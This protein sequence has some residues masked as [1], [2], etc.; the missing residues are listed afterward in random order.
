[1]RFTILLV[2]FAVDVLLSLM[3]LVSFPD[4]GRTLRPV[5]RA[6]LLVT[7]LVSW[8]GSLIFLL[9]S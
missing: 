6:I 8:A 3:L 5:P 2:W 4:D 9:V 7:V 1:M